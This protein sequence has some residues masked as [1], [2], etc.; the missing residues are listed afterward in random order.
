MKRQQEEYQKEGIDWSFQEFVDN[1]PCLEL[2]EGRMSVFSLMNEECRL[3]RELDAKSFS[4]RLEMSLG[5]C[6][7][8]SCPRFKTE[9]HEFAIHHFAE[10]VSYQVEGLVKKNKDFVPP[11]VVE[12]L[13]SSRNPLI[14]ELFQTKRN[15]ENKEAG[16]QEGGDLSTKNSGKH[17]QSTV[18]VVHKFKIS[19]DT[20]MSTLRSTNVHYIR[21]I[22]PNASCQPGMFDRKQVLAQLNACG[23]VET[24][25]ISAA[26]YPIR[27]SHHEFLKRY[28]L[29]LKHLDPVTRSHLPPPEAR[30][31]KKTDA[32]PQCSTVER[33][34]RRA[35]R[36]HRSSYNHTR[37]I[38]RSILEVVQL[39]SEESKENSQANESKGVKVGRTKIFLQEEA[40]ERLEQARNKC[41]VKSVLA[42][43][44]CW[45]RHKRRL[46]RKKMMAAVL[47]QSV[48]RGWRAKKN[49]QRTLEATKVI[50]H[51]VR[52]Y[53]T[54]KRL[55][56]QRLVK[57]DGCNLATEEFNNETITEEDSVLTENTRK[58]L[59][60]FPI[61]RP[62]TLDEATT[63]QVPSCFVSRTVGSWFDS[64][65]MN[66]EEFTPQDCF[67]ALGNKQV[68]FTL[69]RGN[70]SPLALLMCN[71]NIAKTHTQVLTADNRSLTMKK[72][73][74]G[75]AI[76]SRRDVEKVPVAFHC[77][78][79]PLPH[80]NTRPRRGT[81]VNT[82]LAGISE[83]V[84]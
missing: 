32:S 22:K 60:T 6:S 64:L 69:T 52:R 80:A 40:M 4:T 73:N 51:H 35:R 15:Q 7:H 39:H 36:R 61:P 46:A 21:C 66:A 30:S 83:M 18:T 54:L 77:K 42:I 11:E 59:Q 33:L 79:T 50:Q 48:W 58:P 12:L 45:R 75:S 76:I 14:Q 71:F 2:I 25:R 43:Q 13:Q 1:R 24:I 38:C 19:L 70:I 29:A 84:D 44:N 82:G 20:L 81:T 28:S 37:H 67:S 62:F 17:R 57:L 5:Q 16:S 26:G 47:I 9:S 72:V 23:V 3:K 68:T 8:F 27:L 78:G 31:S 41:L 49:F 56:E 55:E 65:E 34:K 53:L 10:S 74:R 63:Q